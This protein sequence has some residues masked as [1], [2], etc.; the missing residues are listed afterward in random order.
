M[1]EC[2]QPMVFATQARE[3]RFGSGSTAC[4]FVVIE[5]DRVVDIARTGLDGAVRETTPAVPDPH[6]LRKLAARSVCAFA[7]AH[8][9]IGGCLSRR[10]KWGADTDDRA[11]RTGC[12]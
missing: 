12:R 2:F 8:R 3:V 4:G 5:R 9:D 10:R 1:A 11:C 6:G 7:K